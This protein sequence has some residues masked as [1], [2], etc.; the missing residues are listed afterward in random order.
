MDEIIRILK[1]PEECQQLALIFTDLAHQAQLRAIELR[2]LSHGKKEEVE[3]ELLKALYAYEEVL[4]KKNKRRTHA[5]RTWPMVQRYGIIKAAERAVNRPTDAMGYKV[6]VDMGMKNLTF[7]SVIV[8]Y[9]E[10]FS[11]E[12]VRL[13][14]KRLEELKNI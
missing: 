14:R 3:L 12:I 8:R 2:A 4:T 9:P 10:A 11:Q 6:L 1:T 13:A 5:S 7:E